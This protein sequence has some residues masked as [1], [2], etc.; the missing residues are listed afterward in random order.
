MRPSFDIPKELRRLQRAREGLLGPVGEAQGLAIVGPAQVAALATLVQIPV[1]HERKLSGIL[2][3]SF[4]CFSVS[5]RRFQNRMPL[6]GI[7]ASTF[8]SPG[9]IHMGFLKVAALPPPC[10]R[11]TQ[12]QHTTAPRQGP[13]T[14]KAKA[15]PQGTT[16]N[17]DAHSTLLARHAVGVGDVLA[18]REGLVPFRKQAVLDLLGTT[19]EQ[20]SEI[21]SRL[22]SN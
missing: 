8:S 12:S 3:C 19:E 4:C 18:D 6:S 21:N 5:S 22:F 11:R 15:S 14:K 13:K 20:A 16:P 2:A 9:R 7:A 1:L 17:F 10:L